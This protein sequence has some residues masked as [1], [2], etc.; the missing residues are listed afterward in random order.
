MSSRRSA[1]ARL[2]ALAGLAVSMIVGACAPMPDT[3]Q[4]PTSG[5]DLTVEVTSAVRA[6]IGEPIE[7]QAVVRSV[8]TVPS[9]GPVV[10]TVLVPPGQTTTA[11]GG[12]GWVCDGGD[13]G[14]TCTSMSTVPV[15]GSLPPINVDAVVGGDPYLA[16]LYAAVSSPADVNAD[17][18]TGRGR[19]AVTMPT[20]ADHLYIQLAGAYEL[21]AGG[22]I[23]NGVVNVSNDVLGPS[24]LFTDAQVGGARVV[25][26]L[27]RVVG[28]LFS[29][30]VTITDPRLPGGELSVAWRDELDGVGTRPFDNLGGTQLGLKVPALDLP[31]LTAALSDGINFSLSINAGDYVPNGP[32]S[33][34]ALTY[35]NPGAVLVPEIELPKRIVQGAEVTVGVGINAEQGVTTGPVSA[36]IDL[37]ENTTFLGPAPGTTCVPVPAIGGR[38]RC[39]LDASLIRPIA[40]NPLRSLVG[41]VL[42]VP[43]SVPTIAI[44]VRAE[45]SFTPLTIGVALSSANSNVRT[46]SQ[47]FE[48]RPPGPSIGLELNGA[49]R[50]AGLWFNE[51]VGLAGNEYR[52]AVDNVGTATSSSPTVVLTLPP[53]VTYRSFNSP[54]LTAAARFSCSADVQIVTCTRT[55]GIPVTTLL[56]PAPSFTVQVDVAPGS[57]PEVSAEAT[58][59]AATDIDPESPAKLD[60]ATTRV[61]ATGAQQYGF[62]LS[63]GA[64]SLEGRP[65]LLGGYDV[66]TAPNGRL[67]SI[68]GCATSMDFVPAVLAIPIVGPELV[69]AL[70]EDNT[71]CVDVAR[72]PLTNQFVGTVRTDFTT[73]PVFLPDSVTP[74]GVP[75][76]PVI[77]PRR[78]SVGAVEVSSLSLEPGGVLTGSAFG[79]DPELLLN[80]G[81]SYRID[82]RIDSL[83]QVACIDVADCP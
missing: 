31:G 34:W 40:P 8:G 80:G 21:R 30:P 16:N 32:G 18:D 4:P 77:G 14:P 55:N 9:V 3:P 81:L 66:S 50:T 11:A 26:D 60:S 29:G 72:V 6:T 63:N 24:R 76:P 82:W 38:Q 61:A 78:V 33:R 79:A 59:F 15:G 75:L 1:R 47:T 43:V 23:S 36:D 13:E 54:G 42:P 58:V 65:V 49:E 37:P 56:T 10:V 20:T 83:D 12:T 25:M 7:Y 64:A 41:S 39:T 52:I 2:F 57:G 62:E 69:P 35:D 27:R 71:L 5:P 73:A 17:N 22:M 51:G 70:Y 74:D 45:A 46:T 19:I 44:R 48:A 53:G 68:S 28:T 67:E